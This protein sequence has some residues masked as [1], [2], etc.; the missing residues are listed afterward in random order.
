MLEIERKYLLKPTVNQLLA[1]LPH[2]C[3]M[4]EQYYTKVS[5]KRSVRY[6]KIGDKYYKT[7]KK[8]KGAI[9]EEIEREIS[10]K[11]FHKHLRER[12]GGVIRKKR[13]FIEVEEQEYSID[14]FEGGL[15][16]LALMEVEFEKKK[17]FRK[18]RLPRILEAYV[19]KEVSEEE[20]YTN[21][22]LALFGL[23]LPDGEPGSAMEVL[24]GKLRQLKEKTLYYR[25]KVLQEGTDEDLHQLR[26]SLRTTVSLLD[27]CAFLCLKNRCKS[28]KKLLK[29]II[30][31]T[32]RKRDIDVLKGQLKRMQG[33][34]HTPQMRE[35]ALKLQNRLLEMEARESR[36]I[37]AY[38]QSDRFREIMEQYTYFIHQRY[39]KFTSL[40]GRYGVKPVCSY[41]ILRSFLK[42]KKSVGKIDWVHE[43]EKLHK[44]RIDF[45]KLRYLLENFREYYDDAETESLIGEV[46]KVQ[47]VLGEFHDAVQ[48]RTIFESLLRE[49]KAGDIDFLIENVI[50]PKLHTFQQ[51]EIDA[52]RKHVDHFLQKEKR[53]R[54]ILT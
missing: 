33:E 46:K 2:T 37:K 12:I 10:K 41:V 34:V 16:G 48:Q 18:F 28:E 13:C 51:K 38:L 24:I 26:V 30:S 3:K 25:D 35:A 29:E 49:E 4:I 43:H 21:R 17:A 14:L 9:R 36:Y 31:I 22:N 7:I 15:E 23:P 40:Y 53:F 5:Q 20:A 52:I 8:G 6:R 44:L 27:Q 32:N 19:E 42:I 1:S 39:P 54:A 50:L 11:L 45:K 47:K